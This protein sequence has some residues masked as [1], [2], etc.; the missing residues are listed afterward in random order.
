MVNELVFSFSVVFISISALSVLATYT[1]QPLVVAFIT[2]GL[3][4]GPAG[5]DLI[6]DKE[7]FEAIGHIGIILLL[8][9]V[10]LE[11]D[12]RD[13]ALRAVKFLPLTVLASAA[14]FT[15]MFFVGWLFQIGLVPSLF[16]AGAFMFSS[17]AVV[18]KIIKDTWGVEE[19]V[20]DACVSIL[21]IQD[22]IA[23]LALLII[24]SY[25]VSNAFD[26]LTFIRFVMVGIALLILALAVERF[27]VGKIFHMHKDQ[28]DVLILLGLAWCFF[29]AELA[30]YLQFSREIGAFIAG[31]SITYFPRNKYHAFMQ[32]SATL[33]DF[34]V[35]LFFFI[36]GANADWGVLREYWQLIAVVVLLSVIGKPIVYYFATKLDHI[37]RSQQLEVSLRLGQMSEFSVILLLAGVSAGQIGKDFLI[38][39]EMIMFLSIIFSNY[40]VMYFPY[41]KK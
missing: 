9:L 12:P 10:G 37:N 22:V 4:I 8:F 24:S 40:L 15:I 31:L 30:E 5:F 3:L 34:F 36:L 6:G 11:L 25:Q 39:V 38:V 13:F 23:V 1:R 27:L 16:L 17:T 7:F 20:H 14:N 41:K 35:I 33:R 32:R 26:P 18:I 28:M 21:I 29:F 19:E 2:A